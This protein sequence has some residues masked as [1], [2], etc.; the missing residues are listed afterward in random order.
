MTTWTHETFDSMSWHDNHVHSLRIV[1][2]EHGAGELRLD[3]D[4]ITDK[5]WLRPQG[6][7]ADPGAAGRAFKAD[8]ELVGPDRVRPAGSRS[9]GVPRMGGSVWRY[10]LGVLVAPRDAIEAAPI[11]VTLPLPVTD[12]GAVVSSAVVG[13]WPRA[14]GPPGNQPRNAGTASGSR[15]KPHW[16]FCGDT[17]RTARYPCT[18][19]VA[20][21]DRH[22]TTLRCRVADRQA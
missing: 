13:S 20:R 2:G 7:G 6:E 21:W 15:H 18:T 8:T 16:R 19:W 11:G 17:C 12:A 4:Y 5:Q 10:G 9:P 22:R 1:E 3:L 14:P